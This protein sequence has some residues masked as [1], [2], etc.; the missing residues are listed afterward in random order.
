MTYEYNMIIF[1]GMAIINVCFSICVYQVVPIINNRVCEVSTP[2]MDN[3]DTVHPPITLLT[4][5]GRVDAV[6]MGS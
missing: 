1:Q 4:C 6:V 2:A 5:Y 3:I